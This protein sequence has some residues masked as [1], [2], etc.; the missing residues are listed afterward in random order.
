[1]ARTR[2]PQEKIGSAAW[3]RWT[4]LAFAVLALILVPFLLLEEHIAAGL[5]QLLESVRDRPWI[6]AA[7]IILLLAGDCVLPVPSSIVSAFAGAAFGWAIGTLVIFV[8]MT[9]GCL[10]GYLVGAG[11]GR[12]L[13]VRVVGEHELA[14]AERLFGTTGPA[15][16]VVARAIPVLAEASV[17]AAGAVRTS[18]TPFLAWT[19]IANLGI[20]AAYAATGAA[21]ARADSFLI[22]FLGLALVPAIGWALWRAR[23]R[24]ED[25]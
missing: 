8:G 9:L 16:L 25:Q 1:M 15:A 4:C 11:A 5:G 3:V 17:M 21:A 10:A 22:V 14:R 19:G 23:A 12:V 2:P 18:M 24:R 7:V 6:G 13:A 20:S